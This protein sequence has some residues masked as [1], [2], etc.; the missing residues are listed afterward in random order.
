MS[1]HSTAVVHPG[2]RLAAD[3]EVGPYAIIGDEVEIADGSE[4][5]AHV[6][7]AGPARIGQRNRF[8]PACAIGLIP[9]DLKFRGERSEVVIGDDNTFREFCT[10]H[11][12]TAS[13]SAL[14]RIG[15]HNFIMAYVHIA[16]DCVLGDHIILGNGA[17]LAGHVR[18]EDYANVGAFCGV[19]QFCRIGRHSFVGGY[20]VLTQD[21]LPFS[22]TVSERETRAYGVNVVGLERRGFS[23]ER[24]EALR[25]ALRLLTQS[26]RN[27]TQALEQIRASLD[28]SA[29]IEELV[30][31]IETSER[32]IIK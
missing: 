13:G 32:G 10:V 12:G 2:A 18:I 31:F 3:V 14:T 17:T 8:F 23:T 24:I 30:R 4:V 29:D 15:S 6:V 21:V 9:Q 16:H 20:S 5:Q 27:T 1:V 7:I 28:R 25:S 19:H 11:R 22:R 26:K